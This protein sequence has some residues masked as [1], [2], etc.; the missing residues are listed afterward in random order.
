VTAARNAALPRLESPSRPSWHGFQAPHD[1]ELYGFLSNLTSG[2]FFL[3]VALV[4]VACC[5]RTSNRCFDESSPLPSRIDTAQGNVMDASDVMEGHG[6]IEDGG[7]RQGL[8]TP[9]SKVEGTLQKC[10]TDDHHER[11]DIDTPALRGLH[12]DGS[13][14]S[15][16]PQLLPEAMTAEQKSHG[17]ETKDRDTPVKE[18]GKM[19]SQIYSPMARER[20]LQSPIF[21]QRDH[22]KGRPIVSHTD[23]PCLDLFHSPVVSFAMNL[24]K[25]KNSAWLAK[26]SSPLR[27]HEDDEIEKVR[28]AS[29][30]SPASHLCMHRL[31]HS[32]SAIPLRFPLRMA[33]KI[34]VVKAP[35]AWLHSCSSSLSRTLSQSSWIP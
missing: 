13:I 23:Q 27:W 30:R 10:L 5:I 6:G 18:S 31:H 20:L 1:K 29:K 15:H 33:R 9:N 17:V 19:P 2:I 24:L 11:K 25:D 4:T 22:D 26:A 32:A 28:A 21:I 7:G 8:K 12:C 34:Q 3:F 14:S 35:K 16:E